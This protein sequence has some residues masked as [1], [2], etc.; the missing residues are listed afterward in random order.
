MTPQQTNLRNI[1]SQAERGKYYE[2]NELLEVLNKLGKVNFYKHKKD[3]VA[4]IACSF[5]IETS[6][7][8]I[9]QQK[10]AFMYEWSFCIGGYVIIG[11]T[12]QQF[13]LLLNDLVE[14][15]NLDEHTILPIYVHN[16][17]FEFQ[18]IRKRFTWS[19]V[20]SLHERKPIKART[21]KGI[22]F[23]CSYLLSGY[24]LAK[25]ADQLLVYRL[26]KLK[27]DLDYNKVRGSNTP[28]S[29]KELQYCINDVLVVF[30]YIQEKIEKLGRI[31]RITLTKTGVVREYCR[32]ECFYENER[33]TKSVKFDKYHKL[34]KRLTLTPEE[35]QQ[36][37]NA[38]SGGFTH[39][40]AIYMDMTIPNVRSFDFT[41]S[42]P[43]VMVS[44]KF[45]MSKPKLVK[46]K[47]NEDFINKLTTYCCLFELELYDVESIFKPENYIAKAHC[48]ELEEP[49]L[50]NGRVVKA[51]HLKITITERDYF[52]IHKSYKW[53]DSNVYNFR[54]FVK[55]YLPTDFVKSI[56][57]LY[58][59]KTTL[60]GIKGKES[61]YLV[62]KENLNSCYGMSV[63]DI[64]RDEII[65]NNIWSK[66]KP[67]LETAMHKYNKSI[68]RFLYY[69]W[70][71]WVTAY[72]RSNLWSGIFEFADDYIYSDT[73]S[74]KVINYE[75]HK[76]YFDDYNNNVISKLERAMQHHKIPFEM[77]CPV[78]NKGVKKQLGIWDDEGCYDYFKTLGAKRYMVSKPNVLEL[79]DGRKYDISIT[80]AGVNKYNAVPYLLETYKNPFSAFTEN[81]VI[82][83][84]YTGKLTH[85]YIDDHYTGTT[86]DYLGNEIEYDE[87]SSTHLEPAEYSLSITQEYLDYVF[88]IQNE[89][90][91]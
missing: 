10:I 6:S 26:H 27:G 49:T 45:P 19:T 34:M 2:P 56:L 12:W 64:C 28:L 11:R 63:T 60:K 50:N 65:Y 21:I 53:K 82:P 58:H 81:L 31:T 9:T 46:I 80:V 25:L 57:K 67:D 54:I 8:T 24:S 77:T 85:T 44:E 66:D 20:F 88:Q 72:A 74:I 30:A 48:K 43:Y 36:S 71:V 59:D 52:I 15:F 39:A 32:N 33:H 42:Y 47:D 14:F 89:T 75:K 4:N 70:G 76:K 35:Y 23:R 41:S 69:P 79:D 84:E 83:K 78:N 61:E 38:F 51:K 68:K 55:D 90:T 86:I 3:Y 18:F 29:I 5:D 62:S 13:D 87:Y 17:S 73:D 1:L 16:L 91:F 40:N 7:V 37:K 22:E